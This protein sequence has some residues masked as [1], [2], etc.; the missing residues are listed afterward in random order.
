MLE[1]AQRAALVEEAPVEA[2]M[3]VPVPDSS[4]PAAIGYAHASHI[5]FNEA[6]IKNRYI[7]RTFIQP[8]DHIRR[9]GIALKFNPLPD[10]LAGKR[11]ILI[12]DS[13]VRG[14][15]AG[16][17]AR[18]LRDAGVAE[19]HMRV[20]CPP[21]RHPCFMGVDMATYDELLAHNMTIE[22][23][24]EHIGCDTLHYLSLE[25]MIRAIGSQNGYCNACF[26]GVYPFALDVD[27]DKQVF[28]GV[29]GHSRVADNK[30]N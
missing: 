22:Q 19:I 11:V 16:P 20:T 17:M 25:G 10:N 4:V 27:L 29:F 5:P 1:G 8:D 2:D 24:R 7:G 6:L 26:T 28:E 30:E 13:I 3:V 9:M 12:D 21:I 14:N 15:T 23:I 18:L